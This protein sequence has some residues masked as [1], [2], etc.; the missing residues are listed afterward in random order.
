M[1]RTKLCGNINIKLSIDDIKTVEQG[2]DFV[3][4]T[5]FYILIEHKKAKFMNDILVNFNF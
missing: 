3:A 5:F 2:Q 4:E 1:A